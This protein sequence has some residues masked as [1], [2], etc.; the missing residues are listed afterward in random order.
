MKQLIEK[1]LS[2]LL[3]WGALGITLIITDRISSEPANYG[4]AALLSAVAGSALFLCL[5]DFREVV[6]SRKTLV[7]ILVAFLASLINSV[8]LSESALSKGI[9]GTF[10]RS[11]GL[12]TYFSLSILIL[13]GSV[14][15][16][17]TSFLLILRGLFL[18]G[19]VNLLLSV[20][21]IMGQDLLTWQNPNLLLLGTLGNTNFVG[22]FL[23]I[24]FTLCISMIFFIRLNKVQ[25]FALLMISALTFYAILRTNALQ[26]IIVSG[27][28]TLIV[29]GFYIKSRFSKIY[30]IGF[31]YSTL[32][33]IAVSI[34]GILQIGPLAKYLYK[35]SVTLRGEYWQAAINMGS[36]NIF[37]G[38]GV[39]SYG[40]NYRLYRDESALVLPGANVTTDA[41]HNVFLDF[42]AG[43][44]LP[45][46]LLYLTLNGFV[47]MRAIKIWQNRINHDFVG[48]ALVSMWIAYVAQSIVSINQVG[49]AVWG[50]VLAGLVIG[51]SE[52]SMVSPDF[53]K[54]SKI[55]LKEFFFPFSRVIA[56][57]SSKTSG[58]IPASR[59]ISS[60]VGLVLGLLSGLMPL[61]NDARV[62]SVIESKKPDAFRS[63]A[64]S[65]PQD[66][67]RDY[68]LIVEFTK[69]G[70]DQDAYDLALESTKRF[71][72]E[73]PG[74]FSLY[75]L[76]AT[77][78]PKKLELKRK[79][80]QLDPLNPEWK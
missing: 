8:L 26:G 12:L 29:L 9:F 65:W 30:S 17:K 24:Y 18:A 55:V 21:N 66:S 76:T 70:R 60:F 22:S 59:A 45:G 28:G 2:L 61:I 51:Y 32:V 47:L 3:A 5:K 37:S 35:T 6:S 77:D 34:L 13:L 10:G 71:P 73:F 58:L 48:V 78:S 74:W 25:L 31:L 19:S 62:R 46:F 44:G 69:Y 40:A 7:F 16:E 11:T 20:F 43:S 75:Q 42:F 49:L 68:R 53:S 36:A 15:K 52:N 38:V 50:W 27:L 39:D 23:G 14:L 67:V 79:L 72:N 54:E 33:L 63:V 57:K 64:N 56:T 41:A 4:K 80:Q 1:R